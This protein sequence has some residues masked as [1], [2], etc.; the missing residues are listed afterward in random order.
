[1]IKMK[2]STELEKMMREIDSAK[3]TLKRGKYRNGS[4]S[5]SNVCA[6]ICELEIIE[7]KLFKMVKEA[8]VAEATIEAKENFIAQI[9]VR[10]E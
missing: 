2:I 9:S 5:G 8:L 1:M 6:T 10:I 7:E 3:D 4:Y